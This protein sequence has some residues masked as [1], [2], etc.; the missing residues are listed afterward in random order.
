MLSECKDSVATK[1]TFLECGATA[2][3]N[4]KEALNCSDSIRST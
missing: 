3:P 1:T 4:R 2:T